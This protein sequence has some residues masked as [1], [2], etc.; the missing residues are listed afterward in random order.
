MLP[1]ANCEIASNTT[2]KLPATQR[3]PSRFRFATN[4]STATTL[5]VVAMQLHTASYSDV[6]AT[7]TTYIVRKILANPK[8]KDSVAQ[9][10]LTFTF[11]HISSVLGPNGRA[12][13]PAT[14]VVIRLEGRSDD[15]EI[16]VE[17]TPANAFKILFTEVGSYH[18]CVRNMLMW[19][20]LLV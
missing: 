13:I 3:A 15:S 9:W 7:F 2:V 10:P 1:F 18:V 11:P 14:D 20:T 8:P 16:Q 19:I 17:T 4:R 6:S 5:I 12:A